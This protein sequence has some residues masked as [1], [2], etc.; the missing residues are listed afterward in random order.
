MSAFDVANFLKEKTRE[1]GLSHTEIARRTGL[2][3]Q[4][5]Y[6]LL[7]GDIQEAKFSTLIKVSRALNVHPVELLSL[8]FSPHTLQQHKGIRA[9]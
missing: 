3:R 2:S 9:A 1:S 4:T 7:N 6:K 8:Y 5:R